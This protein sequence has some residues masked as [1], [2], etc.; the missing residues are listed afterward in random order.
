MIEKTSHL[1]LLLLAFL[2]STF[3]YSVNLWFSVSGFYL[4]ILTVFLLMLIIFAKERFFPVNKIDFKS[5]FIIVL[6]VFS[7][8]SFTLNA[9]DVNG[10]LSLA[11]WVNRFALLLT[12]LFIWLYFLRGPTSKI[13]NWLINYKYLLLILI[14]LIVQL[15]LV[16]IVKIPDIDVYRVLL[17][18]PLR[19][20]SFENPYETGA[21]NPNLLS[22]N[23][24]YQ[25]YAYGPTTI[26]L[27]LPFDFLM[28]EPR[29][30]LIIANFLAT[31][32]IYKVA[33]KF[34]AESEVSEIISL[35]FLFNPRLIYFFTYSWTDG[36]IVSLIFLGLL[37]FVKR[38]FIRSG[39]L[40][41]LAIGVKIFYAIPFLFFLKNK[42]FINKGFILAGLVT[43]LLIHIPFLLLN[44]KAMYKSIVLINVGG[45]TFAQ[46]QRYTLTL[47]TFLDRQYK[48]YP[49][50]IIFPIL[51][52]LTAAVFWVLIRSTQNFSKTLAIVSLVFVATL[53]LGPIANSNYYFTASQ[54]LLF[55]IA[56]S[57]SKKLLNG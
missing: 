2:T 11:M 42:A 15:T 32:S 8:L 25:H 45:G 27:F 5:A 6:L 55:A 47:A 51:I 33:K 7:F 53:F 49:P 48:Y 24:G 44:W 30:L 10:L 37:F 43:F 41:S 20:I 35:I 13:L 29:Y 12:P 3:A 56:V 57:G 22:K 31:F 4:V 34:W 54:I 9:E 19:L 1:E 46:L 28:R 17:Y 21:T 38:E 50:Q 16:R 18:G 26:F 23:Y 14:S 36:L 52:I 39:V 40:M